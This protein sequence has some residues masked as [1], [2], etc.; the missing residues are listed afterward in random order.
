M[1]RCIDASNLLESEKKYGVDLVGPSRKDEKW[2]ARTDSGHALADIDIDIDKQW[3]ICPEGKEFSIWTRSI[4]HGK[5]TI[6]IN[7]GL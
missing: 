5:D 7:K 4:D 1:W 6:K 2:Q 3:A